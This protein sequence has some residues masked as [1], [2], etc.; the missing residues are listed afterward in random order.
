MII[1]CVNDFFFDVWCCVLNVLGMVFCC[2]KINI[3]W[4]FKSTSELIF[5]K[6]QEIREGS[7]SEMGGELRRKFKFGENILKELFFFLI[8]I[9]YIVKLDVFLFDLSYCYIYLL[10]FEL[11]E[12]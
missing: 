12:M 9:S 1:L 2:L 7:Y 5:A 10:I 4:Q 6:R 11:V 8:S 3:I